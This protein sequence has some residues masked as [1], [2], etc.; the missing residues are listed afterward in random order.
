LKKSCTMIDGAASQADTRF[1]RDT[2]V[3]GHHA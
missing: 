3:A 2:N 1:L